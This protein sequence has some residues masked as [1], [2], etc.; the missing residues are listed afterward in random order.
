MEALPR[1]VTHSL[2]VTDWVG[3]GRIIQLG[4]H[5]SCSAKIPGCC[6][7]PLPP[8]RV[9][10]ESS[11][12]HGFKGHT[13]FSPPSAQSDSYEPGVFPLAITR[14]RVVPLLVTTNRMEVANNLRNQLSRDHTSV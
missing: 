11:I 12:L 2:F 10:I 3:S 13:S 14:V 4:F 9:H 8:H 5:K 6:L 1:S 7:P